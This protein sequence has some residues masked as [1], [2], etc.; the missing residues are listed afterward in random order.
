MSKTTI[1]S[2]PTSGNQRVIN[3]AG[4]KPN[5]GVNLPSATMPGWNSHDPAAA[6]GQAAGVPTV[7]VEAPA[8]EIPGQ[9]LPFPARSAPATIQVAGRDGAPEREGN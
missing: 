8:G 3:V 7:N 1:P 2:L 9:P 6:C 5:G 4:S